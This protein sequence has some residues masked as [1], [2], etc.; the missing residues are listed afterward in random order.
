MQGGL[1]SHAHGL[2]SVPRLVGK[3]RADD[4]RNPGGQGPNIGLFGVLGG[5]SV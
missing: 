1:Q 2:L 3:A 4:H 5:F